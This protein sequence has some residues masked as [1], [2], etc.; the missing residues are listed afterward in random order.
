MSQLEALSF[1]AAYAELESIVT[2]LDAG[3]LPL[4]DSVTLF[5][6]GKRL[7]E[8]CQRLLDQAELRI[9]QIGADA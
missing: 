4:E 1:E 6:R 3:D 8:Y 2:R 7:S 9:T 5:E